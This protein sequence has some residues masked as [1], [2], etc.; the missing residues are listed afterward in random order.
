MW[1]WIEFGLGFG[2]DFGLSLDWVWVEFGFGLSLDCV[3]FR[4]VLCLD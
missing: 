1:V 3:G 4:F 2:S